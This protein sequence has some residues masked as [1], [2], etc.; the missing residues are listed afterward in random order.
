MTKP[1]STLGSVFILCLLSFLKRKDFSV[2]QLGIRLLAW[3]PS[4][5]PLDLTKQDSCLPGPYALF[6]GEFAIEIINGT[7][8]NSLIR[9]LVCLKGC[10]PYSLDCRRFP[11]PFQSVSRQ[12]LEPKWLKEAEPPASTRHC[13]LNHWLPLTESPGSILKYKAPS[14]E[15]VFTQ[16]PVRSK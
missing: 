3:L 7:D 13:C 16:K 1:F 4:F 6:Q 15:Y 11:V 14:L 12:N 9:K 10:H 2:W 8:I 5:A